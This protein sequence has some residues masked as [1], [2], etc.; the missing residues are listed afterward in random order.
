MPRRALADKR[1]FLLLSVAAALLYFYL[2]IGDFPEY[3]LWPLKGSA[4]ALLAVYAY[5]RHSSRDARLVALMMAIAALADMAIEFDIKAG[6][7]IFFVYH[8]AALVLYLRNKR[9]VLAPSQKGAVA[10]LLLGT[11]IVGYLLYPEQVAAIYALALGAMAAAAWASNFPRYRVGA[12]AV[13]FVISDWLIFAGMGPLARSPVVENMVWP[14]YYL[15]QFLIT[16]G[17]VTTLRKR[18]PELRVVRS[19]SVSA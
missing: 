15:G 19:G 12:G 18:D 6:A 5:L 1:P 13:L 16:V 7:A 3:F 14:I 4:C 2:R 8:C 9:P 10:A 17:I 11:P